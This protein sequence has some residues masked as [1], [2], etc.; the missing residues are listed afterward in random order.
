MQPSS[1]LDGS[2]WTET[3]LTRSDVWPHADWPISAGV[4]RSSRYSNS[5][6]GPMSL[7]RSWAQL[8]PHW[9]LL[10]HGL[11]SEWDVRDLTGSAADAYTSSRRKQQCCFEA[12]AAILEVLVDGSLLTVHVGTRGVRLAGGSGRVCCP[13]AWCGRARV[14]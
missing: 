10:D 11:V 3:G 5:D 4:M 14:P 1:R 8:V 2:L 12:A 9:R 13:A 7:T 6:Q